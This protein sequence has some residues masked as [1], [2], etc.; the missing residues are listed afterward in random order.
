MKRIIGALFI[1]TTLVSGC[2][3]YEGGDFTDG[4]SMSCGFKVPLTESSQLSLLNLICGTVFKY[5]RN[6]SMQIECVTTNSVKIFGL[7]ESSTVKVT[8]GKFDPCELSDN[9]NAEN[10]D[11]QLK[12]DSDCVI[13]PVVSKKAGDGE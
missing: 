6:G 3:T 4:F 10:E 12:S 1:V 7:Y 11:T 5:D 2:A 9:E 8:K 13:I